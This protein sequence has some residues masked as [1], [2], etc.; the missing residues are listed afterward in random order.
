[1][2]RR[3]PRSTLFPYTTLFR[4]RSRVRSWLR[5]QHARGRPHPGGH[6]E[7]VRIRRTQRLLARAGDRALSDGAR[8]ILSVVVPV[9]DEARSLGDLHHRL[10]LTLKELGQAY[11]I[12]FVDDGSRDGSADVLR[13]LRAQDPA[14]KVIRFNR[15]YGQHA[16]VF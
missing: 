5:A 8:P 2:I 6:L 3:P 1:M 15:N 10:A 12:I 13:A 4:S 11:E 9:F 14:V 7:F 16:A